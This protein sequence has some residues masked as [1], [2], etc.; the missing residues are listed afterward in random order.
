[1]TRP[2]DGRRLRRI[3]QLPQG[4]SVRSFEPGRDDETWVRLNAAA[5]ARHPER[6]WLT[7][8]DLHERMAEPWFDPAGL[9][10]VVEEATGAAG[11]L[12]LDQGRAGRTRGP[13][14]RFRSERSE[15]RDRAGPRPR[16]GR[17]PARDRGGLH[18]PGGAP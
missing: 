8:A 18:H 2:L 10:L 14:P 3:P 17:S 13:G 11:R 6:G 4:F 15:E 12:P 1:M 5:F 16:R 7:V 9:L